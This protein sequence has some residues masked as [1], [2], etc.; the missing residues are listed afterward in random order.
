MRL[1]KF[2]YPALFLLT[3]GIP[4]ARS[5]GEPKLAIESASAEQ[6]NL[7]LKKIKSLHSKGEATY[8]SGELHD[9]W[10]VFKPFL[11][12]VRHDQVEFFLNSDLAEPI[13]LNFTRMT[14][15]WSPTATRWT[16]RIK[17][18]GEASSKEVWSGV[19]HVGLRASRLPMPAQP[20]PPD[21][22]D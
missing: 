5:E 1:L 12:V 15:V 21:P 3:S 10:Q 8:T 4:E 11:I 7:L 14:G 22:S 16:A 18:P 17:R 20:F 9:D 2:L 13:V 6:F 19:D